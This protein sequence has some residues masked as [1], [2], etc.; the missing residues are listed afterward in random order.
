MEKLVHVD[1]PTPP[2]IVQTNVVKVP[3]P[4][5]VVTN[6]R[7]VMLPAPPQEIITVHNYVE[8]HLKLVS[9]EVVHEVQGR[10]TYVD[11]LELGGRVG[12]QQGVTREAKN[13]YV[14]SDGPV[15]KTDV[16]HTSTA[17]SM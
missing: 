13:T 6:V 2:P 9:Q 5:K 15:F 16:R 3:Q 1:A 4:P 7:E 11:G 10:P 12:Y 8:T 14:R 17:K